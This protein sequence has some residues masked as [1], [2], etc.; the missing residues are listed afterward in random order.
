M[1][2]QES[3]EVA[4]DVSQVPLP[5]VFEAFIKELKGD[6]KKL[7]QE[8]AFADPSQ[9]RSFIGQYLY[10][11]VEEMIRLLASMT[12]EAYGIS[13]S[14]VN[15]LRR[16]HYF[17]VNELNGLGADLDDDDASLPGVSPEALNEFQQAFYALG[18]YLQEN[19]PEDQK[20]ES[21]FNVVAQAVSRMVAELMDDYGSDYDDDG[22]DDDDIV[23]EKDAGSAGDDEADD[24]GE[25]SEEELEE[26][27]KAEKAA[28][29]KPAKKAAKKGDDSE[30]EGSDG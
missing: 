23:D 11:R 19:Y 14:N 6:R 25:V 26:A 5:P 9:L 7:L 29:T 16:L 28:K 3:A 30:S 4:V 27:A 24:E 13:A 8:K 12:M 20:L 18:T 10:P 21:R 1:A 22:D 2:D 15:E 17:V